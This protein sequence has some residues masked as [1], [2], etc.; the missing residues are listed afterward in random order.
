MQTKY[1]RLT[2][3]DVIQTGV[4]MRRPVLAG[5]VVTHAD[6]RET[7]EIPGLPSIPVLGVVNCTG[8]PMPEA[9]ETAKR[10]Q[11]F[12]SHRGTESAEENVELSGREASRSNDV[13]GAD[14]HR[15]GTGENGK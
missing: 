8:K 9:R 1:R 13:L 2:Q 12:F 5:R 7:V 14:P 15:R 3:R 6:G 4:A 11:E 10:I